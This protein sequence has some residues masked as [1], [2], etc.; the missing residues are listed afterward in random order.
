MKF[1]K[2]YFNQFGC[3]HSHITYVSIYIPTYMNKLMGIYIKTVYDIRCAILLYYV[4]Y[5]QI[6]KIYMHIYTYIYSFIHII[7][8]YRE[9]K[10]TCVCR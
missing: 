2:L 4:L 1:I 7:T 8:C 5:V 6:Y 3:L 10:C 9:G